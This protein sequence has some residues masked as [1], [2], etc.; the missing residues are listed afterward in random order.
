MSEAVIRGSIEIWRQSA[1]MS[2]EKRVGKA[3]EAAEA[4]EGERVAEGVDGNGNGE[5]RDVDLIIGREVGGLE[6]EFERREDEGGRVWGRNQGSDED[7]DE[8]EK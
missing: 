2:H 3:W 6:D 8:D 7:E 1:Q 5:G 4:G